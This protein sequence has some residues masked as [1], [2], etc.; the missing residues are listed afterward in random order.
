MKI[1]TI[2]GTRPEVIRLSLIIQKLDQVAK[3]VVVHTGQNSDPRLSELFFRELD[4]RAPDHW[5]GIQ[6]HSPGEQVGQILTR[7]EAV[8]RDEKPDAVLILGDTNS[9]LSAIVAKR[10]GIPVFHLEAGNRCF[11]D[12]VPEE[13]NRRIID[14]TSDVLMPYTD[15]SRDHLLAEGIARQR[16]FVVG[17]PIGE[18]LRYHEGA[19]EGAQVLAAL[20]VSKQ[21][22]VLAT[23]HRAENVDDPARLR[24]FASSFHDV[25][26]ELQCPVI[27][28]THPRTRARLA[29]IGFESQSDA[30]QFLAPFGFFDFVHLERH[31][32]LVLTDSGTVQEECAILRV[33]NAT[34]RDTTERPE[35]LECGSNLLTGCDRQRIVDA[36]RVLTKTI[37][38]WEL[39]AGY[40][41]IAVS[42]TVVRIVL[43]YHRSVSKPG[44]S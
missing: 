44:V 31:A 25:A 11:D 29:A 30:V 22:Y 8:L 32:K 4:V 35:T 19:I 17:N 28:S 33:P 3:H 6:A 13:V 14:H 34:L 36:A 10:A 23:L 7:V 12:R 9:G 39:P 41:G 18:V 24:M 40:S 42:D 1:A 37:P 16:I 5:L 38:Q 21:A 43:G 2:L 20:G 27:V 15:R 26:A